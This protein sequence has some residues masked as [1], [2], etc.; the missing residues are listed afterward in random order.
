M[1]LLNYLFYTATANVPVAWL[2]SSHFDAKC[3]TKAV[4]H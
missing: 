1:P 3:M 2:K 4:I